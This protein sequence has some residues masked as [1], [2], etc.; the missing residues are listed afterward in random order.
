MNAYC[1]AQIVTGINGELLCRDSLGQAVA[2]QEPPV[3]DVTM[4]AGPFSAGFVMVASFWALGH[5]IS[6]ILGIVR[7]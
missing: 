2:W 4:V 1:P 6:L 3:V 7:R 5:G